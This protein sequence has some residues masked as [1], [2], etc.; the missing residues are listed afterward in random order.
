V[1]ADLQTDLRGIFRSL[2]KT[3]VL[4]THDLGEAGYFGDIVVLLRD[5]RVVQQGPPHELT[6]S[7]AEPFVT[8]FVSAQ[9]SL[10]DAGR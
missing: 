9:R 7:P 8:Q 5:G 4:V 2:G 1:R 6:D 10:L 3:V